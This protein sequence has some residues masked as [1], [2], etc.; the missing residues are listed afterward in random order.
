[1]FYTYIL[2]SARNSKYYVGYTSSIDGRLKLHNLGKV[3][4]TKNYRPWDLFYLEQ[5]NT[6]KEAINRERQIKF[7]KSRSMIE[8]LKF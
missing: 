6:E 4:A 8:K 1:M 7:W 3:L 5:F 2:K